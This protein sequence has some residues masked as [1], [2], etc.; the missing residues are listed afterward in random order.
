MVEQDQLRRVQWIYSSRDARELEERY[1]RWASDY[2]KDLEEAFGWVGPRSAAEVLARHV[3]RKD[4]R[5]L[6]AGAGTG[7]VG[8]VLAEMGYTDM[9][10]MDFS[11]GMLDEAARK[12]VYRSYD[13]MDMTRELGY[14]N[15][16]FDAVVSVG[17]FT[18]GHVPAGAFD[19]VIRVTRPGGIIV[20]S[21]R[22]D[23]HKE[24]GFKEK[25]EALEAAGKW[26][27]VEASEPF[28]P[29]PN[30]EPEVYHQVW[31]YQVN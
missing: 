28:Q 16:S 17:V 29:L 26:K 5:I 4:A 22:P 13:Q 31:V 23:T 14:P 10:A 25:Q 7:L 3:T 11:K 30:G 8:V 2:D 21:L 24:S 9:V 1:D 12:G 27:L 19:E 15:S 20:F 6:D 18:V